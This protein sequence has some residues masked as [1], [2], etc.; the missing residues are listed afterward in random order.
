VNEPFQAA[1]LAV[2]EI[3]EVRPRVGRENDCVNANAGDGWP[4]TYQWVG[5]PADYKA[6]FAPVGMS[7]AR[8]PMLAEAARCEPQRSAN[9]LQRPDGWI[10]R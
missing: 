3:L 8:R 4:R 6:C 5:V 9:N 10:G 1:G 2:A 7:V